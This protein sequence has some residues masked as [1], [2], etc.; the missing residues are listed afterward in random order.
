MYSFEQIK[1]KFKFIKKNPVRL[2]LAGAQEM[3]YYSQFI[4]NNGSFMSIKGKS[5]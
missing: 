2:S 1:K 4:K 3:K 5:Y